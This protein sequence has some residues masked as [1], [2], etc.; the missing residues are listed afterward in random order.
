VNESTLAKM[1]WVMLN[2]TMPP[3]KFTAIHWDSKVSPQERQQILEWVAA[4]RAAHYATGTASPDRANEPVQPLPEKLAT[5]AR[6]V[7]LGR[8]LFNDV[9]LSGDNTV[10]CASCHSL[11]KA[12]TDGRRFSEGV[13]QQVGDINAPS[14]LN[15]IFNV[16][17]FWNGRA[18][19]LREQAGG[20]P[21]NPIEMA[22]ADWG[23]IIAKL[24]ADR[25]LSEEFLALYGGAAGGLTGENITDAIAE[26]E[27]TL[28]TPNSS[29][30]KWL[31]G[32]DGAITATE[33]E[34][35]MR[36][37]A[38]RCASCHVGKTLGG[39]GFE[40]LDLKKDYFSARGEPLG[41]DEGLQGFTGKERDLHKFKV[42]NLRNVELTHPYM[43]DGTVTS[44]DE[45]VGIMGTYLT[46]M[47][48]PK[49]DRALIVEFLRT[50]TGEHQGQRVK[51]EAVAN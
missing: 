16:K 38:Y 30:D 42:P 51:G 19:D 39:Q 49:Q 20:P 31:K 35:Y 22:S 1:E 40:Y 26:Y 46:G 14:T 23:E 47:E 32:D 15:A 34:G 8:K 48:V 33:L 4:S 29:F 25:N 27:K 3:T 10:S 5:D 9:R 44:L 36:F 7:E 50:L 11:D 17:Q 37:K 6:K 12:G 21:F 28:I 24:R 18:A 2:E 41:S 45:A 13:R 43:H